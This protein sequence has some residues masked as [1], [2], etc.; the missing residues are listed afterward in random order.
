M[1]RLPALRGGET[2]RGMVQTEVA[3]RLWEQLEGLSRGL[4]P[5]QLSIP[6]VRVT[7]DS[8]S[9]LEVFR[10]E[11]VESTIA[12]WRVRGFTGPAAIKHAFDPGR[13]PSTSKAVR[14]AVIL[15]TRDGRAM[16]TER[17]S[18]ESE[19][20]LVGGLVVDAEPSTRALIDLSEAIAAAV[21]AL[22]EPATS[23]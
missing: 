15:G 16:V 7:L 19:E 3:A 20:A 18:D 2:L 17:V 12:A 9:V 10:A 6:T 4:D 14:L 23:S 13:T 22:M 11:P 5:T 8:G 21:R 1:S